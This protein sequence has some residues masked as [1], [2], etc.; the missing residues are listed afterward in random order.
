MIGLFDDKK[1]NHYRKMFF[2]A[3]S[4]K[5]YNKEFATFLQTPASHIIYCHIKLINNNT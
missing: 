5:C 2:L 3:N 4:Y 1:M